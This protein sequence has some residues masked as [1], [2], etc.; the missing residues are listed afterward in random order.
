MVKSNTERISDRDEE[1]SFVPQLVESGNRQN[2]E[3]AQQTITMLS[4]RALREI[5]GPRPADLLDDSKDDPE[6]RVYDYDEDY[7]AP[8]DSRA[9]EITQY[10]GEYAKLPL[11]TAEQEIQLGR[12]VQVGINAIEMLEAHENG[13]VEL[14]SQELVHLQDEIAKGKAAKNEFAL[15]N[16]KLVLSIAKRYK[17]KH[18]QS[19]DLINEGNLGLLLA[20]DKFDPERGF[21]FSTYA[22]W[23][24]RQTI[25]RAI[26]DKDNTVR[27]PVHMAEATSSLERTSRKLE[28]SLSR[29]PTDD[30]LMIE[31]GLTVDQFQNIRRTQELQPLSIDATLGSQNEGISNKTMGETIYS[32]DKIID[33]YTER[34]KQDEQRKLLDSI[35]DLAKL[36]TREKLVI[37]FRSGYYQEELEG[38][39][40]TRDA[41]VTTYEELMAQAFIEDRRCLTLNQISEIFDVS[42]ERIRQIEA[43]ALKKMEKAKNKLI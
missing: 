30:E 39:I 38:P 23:W 40:L 22:T 9:S 33:G 25:T 29:E 6:K 3:Q 36:D 31:H 15:H 1:I 32:D 26:D 41:T 13:Q 14:S 18:L 17:T 7:C 43:K 34:L 35:I 20:I 19:K 21:K 4:S 16:L 37:S 42:R 27:I 11:L 24:I 10:L 8:A 2:P 12:L 28:A 5:V